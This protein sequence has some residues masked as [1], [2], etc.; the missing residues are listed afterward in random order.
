MMGCPVIRTS[1]YWETLVIRVPAE[2]AGCRMLT[3]SPS[4]VMDMD[5]TVCGCVTSLD[6][7]WLTLVFSSKVCGV[8]RNLKYRHCT[9]NRAR[10]VERADR[11]RVVKRGDR[12]LCNTPKSPVII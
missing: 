8:Y 12:D 5:Q 2:D 3:I 10:K 11:H 4:D 1:R 6:H 7:A 9:K